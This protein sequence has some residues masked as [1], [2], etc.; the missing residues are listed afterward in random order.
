MY[1][2]VVLLCVFVHNIVLCI[3]ILFNNKTLLYL[4]YIE[5]RFKFIVFIVFTE[6]PLLFS[7]IYFYSCS[8]VMFVNTELE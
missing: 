2:F 8:H 5:N 4:E 6:K 7:K 1:E 3:Y